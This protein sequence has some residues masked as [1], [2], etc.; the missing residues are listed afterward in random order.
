MN[1]W[2]GQGRL[3]RDPQMRQAGSSQVCGFSIACDLGKDRDPLWMTCNA[4]GSMG[5]QIL[6]Y[7]KQGKP[8]SVWGELRPNEFTR[9]DNVYRDFQLTVKG[10]GFVNFG[11]PENKENNESKESK[12]EFKDPY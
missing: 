7:F 8:I 2:I 9:G 1:H 10:W 6:K 5:D 11:A 3:G 12:E 4:W